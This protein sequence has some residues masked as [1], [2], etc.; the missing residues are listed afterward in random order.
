[1]KKISWTMRFLFGLAFLLPTNSQA[2]RS[3]GKIAVCPDTDKTSRI[4]EMQK[5]P[6]FYKKHT[7][8]DRIPI[9]CSDKV[10]DSAL[11][12][13]KSIVIRMLAKI[14]GVKDALIR[15][16]LQVIIV[17]H[18]ELMSDIPEYKGFDVLKDAKGVMLNDRLRGLGP[19][20]EHPYI[21][22]AEE[23]L[24]CL[25]SDRYT[26]Q[27]ILVHEFAH[28]I[29]LLG[30]NYVDSNFNSKLRYA[31]LEAKKKGLW[32][33]TYAISN[34]DEY[35]AVGVQCWFNVFKKAVPSDGIGNEISRR[36]ELRF[37]DP[38]LYNL[39]SNYF[40][41]DDNIQICR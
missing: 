24:I 12:I 1:M 26:G 23:N 35:F 36:S 19:M 40:F 37:Y 21:S 3:P 39:L 13:A 29:A 17:S 16:K 5:Y 7:D 6:A 11:L 28:A 18:N 15:N 9:I 10:N 2:A 22:C 31:Y 33:N 38:P 41:M 34:A 27:S 25:P 14:P 30:I 4:P 32:Q 8:A 20:V